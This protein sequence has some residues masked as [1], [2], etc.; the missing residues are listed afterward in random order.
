MSNVTPLLRPPAPPNRTPLVLDPEMQRIYREAGELAVGRLPVL[1][2]GET[3]VGKE[4]LAEVLHERSPR[5]GRPF[6]RLNCAAVTETLFESELFGHERGAFTGGDREKPGLLETAGRGTVFLDEVGELAP[7]LQAKLLRALETG[8]AHRVGG[9][10]PRPIEARFVSATNAD[11]LQAV[12][13]G[14]FR[15]D[16][17][18]RLAGAVLRVPPLRRRPAEILPL[19]EAFAVEAARDLGWAPPLL[20][21]EA[22]TALLAH[23]WPGNVRELR[24]AIERAVLL[25]RAGVV[26]LEHLAGGLT[27]AVTPALPSEPPPEPGDRRASVQRALLACG[28]NQKEA[29]RRLGVD[30]RTLGRWLDRLGMPRPRKADPAV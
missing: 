16:L 4:H 27:P 11:L 22:C 7:S 9:V 30:R 20:T 10:I 18:H 12:G 15:R 25:A 6:V 29:A 3:G 8:A 5:T 28:G 17:Y 24:N 23:A 19:A 14:D 2:V 21:P 13:S 26:G 1:I